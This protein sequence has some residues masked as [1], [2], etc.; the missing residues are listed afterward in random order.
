[1]SPSDLSSPELRIQNQV[2]TVRFNLSPSKSLIGEHPEKPEIQYFNS[3]RVIRRPNSKLLVRQNT[4]DKGNSKHTKI[5]NLDLEMLGSVLGI[6]PEKK[7]TQ[8]T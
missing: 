7:D 2:H 1:M 3:T 5:P 6:H 8:Q 4:E